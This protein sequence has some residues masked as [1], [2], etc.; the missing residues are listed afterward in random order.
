M[1]P[2]SKRTLLATGALSA[3]AVTAAAVVSP[4]PDHGF[5]IPWVRIANTP[6]P[7]TGS[8]QATV[9]STVDARVAGNVG[10]TGTVPVTNAAGSPLLVQ[11]LNAQDEEPFQTILCHQ[12]GDLL[13]PRCPSTIS[14]RFT[15]PTATASG[16]AVRRLVIEHVTGQC[17]GT[18][19]ASSPELDARL[20]LAPPNGFAT[21]FNFFVPTLNGPATATSLASQTFA[22]PVKIYADP[23]TDVTVHES[24]VPTPSLAAVPFTVCQYQITGH[25]VTQ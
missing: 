5:R 25:F 7:V 14:N 2:L 9:L 4:G 19:L 18:G 23:G 12:S 8:V 6:L 21:S 16:L 24:V 11:V 20:S 1:T 15:V 22:Q 17:G 3:V 10:I 13:T